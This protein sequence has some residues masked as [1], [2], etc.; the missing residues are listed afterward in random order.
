MIYP[1]QS[2]QPLH[3]ILI[4][5]DNPQNLEV[6]GKLLHENCFE[7]EFAMS[8]EATIEWLNSRLFDLILLDINMPGMNGFEVCTKIRSEL[9]L[10]R[11]PIIF[12]SA[13]GERS[14]ILKGFELGAQDYVIKPFDSRELLARVRTHLAL[15]NSL[16]QLEELNK[17]LE[18]QVN[19]RTRELKEAR[20]ELQDTNL[21]LIDL[22]KAKTEFLHLI[23]HEIR[24]PLN[25]ILGPV[26]LIRNKIVNQDFGVLI[27]ILDT[28]VRRLERFSLNALL[29]TQFKTKQYKIEQEEIQL[30]ALLSD[31]IE[32][33]KEKLKH[34]NIH[35]IFDNASGHYPITGEAGLIMKCITN[36]LDNA[37]HFSPEHGSIHIGVKVEGNKVV[38]HIRDKGKGFD[39]ASLSL[40]FELFK[41]GN[42]GYD[43]FIGIGL[44]IVKMIMEAHQ[45]DVL[46]GNNADGGAE[47]SLVFNEHPE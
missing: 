39:P 26:E 33:E 17:T 32:E 9:V 27:G 11:I 10:T 46:I 37:I 28:S 36:I 45:G 8:G 15:K 18:D 41:T 47:V 24:T 5:D 40:V 38:C 12:L 22:D 21:K 19:E 34:K 31:V 4:V 44:P 25:G 3:S 16:E 23:S 20:D 13:E 30:S 35:I 42:D 14:S 29:I 6:L 7:V 1:D 2:Q 43:N